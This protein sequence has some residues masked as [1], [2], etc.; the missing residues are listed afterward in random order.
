MM[1]EGANEHMV[2]FFGVEDI[3]GLKPEAAMAARKIFRLLPDAREIGEQAESPLETRV[4]GL[5]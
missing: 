4:I 5:A 2:G 3:V 1:E